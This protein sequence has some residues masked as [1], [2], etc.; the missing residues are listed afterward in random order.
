[1][2]APMPLRKHSSGRWH[3]ATLALRFDDRGAARF[4][5]SREAA[6]FVDVLPRKARARPAVHRRARTRHREDRPL[7][8]RRRAGDRLR[9]I[10]PMAAIPVGHE[11]ARAWLG[12]GDVFSRVVP[13]GP[14]KPRRRRGLPR[15]RWARG[16]AP[17]RGPSRGLPHQWTWGSPC[18]AGERPDRLA[19]LEAGSF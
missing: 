18:C 17:S 6:L 9:G 7:A 12:P 2:R 3:R 14:A 19:C 1:M 15:R 11:R 8:G 10:L 5:P 13:G 16:F 4:F